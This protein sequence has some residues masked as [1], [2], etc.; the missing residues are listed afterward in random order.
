MKYIQGKDRKQTTIFPI[1]M[2]VPIDKDHEVR[3][4]DLFVDNAGFMFTA[5]N[6][7]RIL[8]IIG[9]EAF[10]SYL[11]AF[12]IQIRSVCEPLKPFCNSPNIKLKILTRIFNMLI[13]NVFAIFNE[14]FYPIYKLA[15]G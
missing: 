6:L 8:N 4:L 3:I 9:I 1:S 13:S 15:I 5:Y 12:C 2:E 14:I 10:R 7:R 11:L